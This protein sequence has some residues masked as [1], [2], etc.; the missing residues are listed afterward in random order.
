MLDCI[1]FVLVYTPTQLRISVTKSKP[2]SPVAEAYRLCVL[3]CLS[4][5]CRTVD[6]RSNFLLCVLLAFL[7][8]ASGPLRRFHLPWPASCSFS[9]PHAAASGTPPDLNEMPDTSFAV[10]G[11]IPP[12]LPLSH[13][14][15]PSASHSALVLAVAC[16]SLFPCATPLNSL[17]Q[18]S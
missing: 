14:T 5:S 7:A 6:T 2:P 10:P 1:S 3:A 18:I 8:Y 9:I 13:K 4:D 17:P 11:G 16:L 12:L 15:A